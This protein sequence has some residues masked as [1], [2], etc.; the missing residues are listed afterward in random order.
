MGTCFLIVCKIVKIS[1]R[2]HINCCKKFPFL[3]LNYSYLEIK[4]GDLS[5]ILNY[6]H[7]RS[8]LRITR[9]SY[10]LKIFGSIYLKDILVVKNHSTTGQNA[11]YVKRECCIVKEK[12]SLNKCYYILIHMTFLK[13]KH[14][15]ACVVV[16]WNG[17]STLVQEVDVGKHSKSLTTYSKPI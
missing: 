2:I 17:I 4:F 1:K 12:L 14:K 5:K 8:S 13:V 9:K 11:I 3:R 15:I 6:V 7:S 10:L 16:L